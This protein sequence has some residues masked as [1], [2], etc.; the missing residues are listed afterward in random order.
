MWRRVLAITWRTRWTIRICS[1]PWLQFIFI[2]HS[3]H[4]VRLFEHLEHILHSSWTFSVHQVKRHF[5]QRYSENGWVVVPSLVIHGLPFPCPA[6]WNGI[7][8]ISGERCRDA[9]EEKPQALKCILTASSC[10]HC[11]HNISASHLARISPQTI[12]ISPGNIMWY[13]WGRV[14]YFS[15]SY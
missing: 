13:L 3:A 4:R 2:A 5:E 7:H 15:P 8:H 9:K 14:K 1:E 12:F 11:C 6:D 10:P